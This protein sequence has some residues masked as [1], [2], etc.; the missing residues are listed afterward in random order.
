MAFIRF[1]LI[2]ILVLFVGM[3]LWMGYFFYFRTDGHGRVLR[4]AESPEAAAAGQHHLARADALLATR[5]YDQARELLDSLRDANLN[6][7]MHIDSDALMQRYDSLRARRSRER[8][9]P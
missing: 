2:A 6:P 5:H 1:A 3:V 8:T 4:E 7:K 9:Q